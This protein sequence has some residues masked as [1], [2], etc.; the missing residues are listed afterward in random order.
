MSAAGG[1]IFVHT[2]ALPA[3]ARRGR[4]YAQPDAPRPLVGPFERP[5][6]RVSGPPDIVETAAEGLPETVATPEAVAVRLRRGGVEV[7]WGEPVVFPDLSALLRLARERGSA[8]VE[9]VRADPSLVTELEVGAFF[10]E[11]WR[12]RIVRRLVSRL[13][14]PPRGAAVPAAL[15]ARALDGAFWSGVRSAAT[16][17]EWDRLTRSSYVVLLYHRIAGELKPGQETLDVTPRRFARQQRLLRLLGFRPL[18]ASEIL[19]FHGDPGATLGGRRYVLTAD[20]AFADAVRTLRGRAHLRPHVFACTSHVGGTAVWAGAEP[21][22]TWDELRELADAGGVVGSHSDA[23]ARLTQ[24]PPDLL[25]RSLEGSLGSLRAHLP[26]A[27]PLLA[28]PHG[29]H[30][31][32]VRSAAAA[33]GY[34][35]AFTTEPGRNGA[36][37]DPYCLRRIAPRDWDGAAAFAWMALTGEEL[38]WALERRR[39][40]R[41]ALHPR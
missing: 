40:W 34:A 8:S 13:A 37:T 7:S 39:R 2:F 17:A 10:H 1:R 20:D 21:V 41:R 29:A 28:Y 22:A 25:A 12:R 38:P 16:P 31:R 26:D 15:A 19:D 24:L 35:A 36:G 4:V 11:Y 5:V 30:D 27:P 32:R 6:V 18:A 3:E 33:A 23:H 14:L 9:L